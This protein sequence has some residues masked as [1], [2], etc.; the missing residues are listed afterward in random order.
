MESF[1]SWYDSLQKPSW[2][3]PTGTIGTIW[4]LLYPIIFLTHG[5][6]LY[7]AAQKEISWITA[8][9]FILNL[10]A[11]FS[12]TPLQFGLR[13]NLLAW[14]DILIILGTIIWS[15]FAIWPHAR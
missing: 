9:P 5:T 2:T 7:K 15:I 12:F 4:S 1:T 8:L 11:N 14:I 13:N 6:V 10:L 3:P